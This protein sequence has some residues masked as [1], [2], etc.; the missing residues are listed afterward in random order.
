MLLLGMFAPVLAHAKWSVI[1]RLYIEEQYDDNI[2]LTERNEQDDFIT[3]IS[4]GIDLKS[5]TPTT[6]LD[7][8]YELRRSLYNDFS[9]LNFTGHRGRAEARKEFGPRFSAG[10]SELFIRSEDPIELTGIPIF[11][12]P[13]IRAG[14]RNRYTL[15]T[16]EPEMIY[17][18]AENSA[19][20]L[21]YR[22]IVLNNKAEDVADQDQDALSALLTYRF[23]IHHGIEFFYEYIDQ[24]YEPTIPPQPLRNFE[25]NELRGRYTYYF[26]PRTS[27]FLEYRVYKR[28]FEGQA[29]DF[30]DYEVH[31]GRAGFSHDLYE[32]VSVSASGGYA[33]R[34]TSAGND[35]GTFSG[36]LDLVARYKRLTADVYGEIGFDDDFLSAEILGFN[37]FRRAGFYGRYQLAQRLWANGTF[38]FERDKFIDLNRRDEL[39][40]VRG[41]LEYQILEWLFASLEY[42]HNERDSNIPFASY[43]DNRYYGR[44]T[45]RY[46]LT[47]HL[48]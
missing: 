15:N 7:L 22:N 25:G 44:I 12:R 30:A 18:F 34:D 40:S 13:S 29:A 8:D 2:F 46:D 17:R 1:P 21:R 26:N 10:I 35:E 3:T 16:V 41:T 14:A 11:E 36:R 39:W 5:E 23:T 31:D 45:V 43:N 28:D 38:Y 9:E 6:M 4:P 37:Q 24:T 42:W 20:R 33:L 32:N 27:A 48:K 19:I 47:E